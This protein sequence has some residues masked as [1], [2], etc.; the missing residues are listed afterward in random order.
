MLESLNSDCSVFFRSN[1][2]VAISDISSFGFTECLLSPAPAMRRARSRSV[3]LKIVVVVVVAVV[4]AVVLDVAVVAATAVA[5]LAQ[6][7]AIVIFSSCCCCCCCHGISLRVRA[8]PQAF[9]HMAEAGDAWRLNTATGGADLGSN[10]I[11]TIFST[12]L[13]VCS[14]CS[15][16]RSLLGC[17]PCCDPGEFQAADV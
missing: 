2:R 11:S 4:V 5:A 16:A 13:C 7:L 17:S 10:N 1:S 14:G 8:R 12:L 6:A 15:R 3:Q 9:L